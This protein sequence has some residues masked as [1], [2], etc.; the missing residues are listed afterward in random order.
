VGYPLATNGDR[1]NDY[2]GWYSSNESNPA[3][4]PRL[5]VEYID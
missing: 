4:H 3:R 5:E 2:R 1:G